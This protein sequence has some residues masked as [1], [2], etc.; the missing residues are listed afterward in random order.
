VGYA[1]DTTHAAGSLGAVEAQVITDAMALAYER[2]LPVVGFL[3][4]AG[5]RLQEGAAALGAFG[6]VFAAN[7]RLSGRVPQI[8]V[9]TGTSAGGGCYSPALTDFVVMTEPSAMFLTGPKVVREVTGEETTTRRLGGV[10]VHQ[11]SGVC[12]L[13]ARDAA[14]GARVARDLLRYLPPRIGL[15]RRSAPGH[16]TGEDPGS[17]VPASRRRVYDVRAVVRA[18]VDE[19]EFL[20]TSPRWARNLVTGFAHLGGWSV[21]IIANQPQ[22]LGGVLDVTAAQKGTQFVTRCERLGIPL[23][24]LVDTPGFLPG[25]RQ[26]TAGIILHGAELV[27]AFASA[28]VPRLTVVLRKAYGG[29]YIT[30]NSKDL[31]AGLAVAWTGAQIGVMGAEAAVH[32]PPRT[33]DRRDAGRPSNGAR[34]GRRLPHAARQRRERARRRGHRRGDRTGRDARPADLRARS[35]LRRDRRGRRPNARRWAATCSS[36]PRIHRRTIQRRGEPST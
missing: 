25:S 26:E 36:T 30:M 9:I 29:G 22:Y 28:T 24:V 27:R 10:R 34:D 35:R 13:V 4:S 3:E 15:A 32:I 12:H 18:L 33:G 17:Y 11:A 7:V 5:A 31:G 20:E 6:R 1:Y 21:G 23:V 19:G 8:S 2:R 14:D 16:P